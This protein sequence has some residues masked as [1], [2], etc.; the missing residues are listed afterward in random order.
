[1]SKLPAYLGATPQQRRQK[2]WLKLMLL[3]SPWFNYQPEDVNFELLHY[4]CKQGSS[5][6]RADKNSS[7]LQTE[8]EMDET[9]AILDDLY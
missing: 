3:N 9:I 1:M 6:A 4:M 8:N 5:N 2:C 7:L